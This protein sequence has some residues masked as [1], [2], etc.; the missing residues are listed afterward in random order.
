MLLFQILVLAFIQGVAEFL[1]ISSHGHLIIVAGL[2]QQYGHET[3]PD[4]VELSIILHAGTLASILVVFRERIWRLLGSDRRAIGLV[5]AGTIPVVLLGLP[6][7]E[8]PFLRQWLE[9]PLLVGFMLP[10]TGL[11]LIFG[12]RHKPGDLDYTQITYR[13]AVIIGCCQ[14]LALL[15]GI[16]RSGVTLVGGLLVGL[17]RE[18]AAT[19]SFLLAI[20]AIS[21]AVVLDLKKLLSTTDTNRPLGMLLIGAFVS[22]IV[23]I[24]SLRLLLRV[25]NRG[26]LA[27]F[28][29]WCIPVGLAT[30]AWQLLLT[31]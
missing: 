1:P 24:A 2:M 25:L 10:I 26:H 11:L 3:M 5:A 12:S 23:G 7:H 18:A 20:A 9:S 21:G 17:R 15:P 6:I 14:C 13:Q 28:A 22:F 4:T 8:I 16:S 31:P 30:I 29:F 27:W 19:F